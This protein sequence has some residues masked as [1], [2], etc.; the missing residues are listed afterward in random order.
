MRNILSR[1]SFLSFGPGA[2]GFLLGSAAGARP[3]ALSS[4]AAAVPVFPWPYREVD[5]AAVSSRAYQG[6]D[7]GG[8][9]FGVFEGI[10]AS[11]AE[12]LGEPYTTFPFALSSYGGGGVSSWGSLCGTCNGAAMA[13]GLFHAGQERTMLTQQLFAWYEASTLPR[14]VPAASSR[15]KKGFE[16]PASRPDSVLCH[17]SISRW[18]GVSGLAAYSPERL[19]RCARLVA[20][21]AGFTTELLNTS[22]RKQ[23]FAGARLS[24]VAAG[25]LGCHAQGKQAPGEPETVS[26]M[27]CT[28]CHDD[29]HHQ[30]KK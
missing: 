14:Y 24:E 1:R 4:G 23:A 13:I 15:V 20:D 8:C 26:R 29:A 16:M 18:T 17:V 25:C 21:V 30:G 9:M 3:R 27:A 2:G 22:A 7:R 11:V 6:F 10:A 28:T 12:K 19:E 5:P